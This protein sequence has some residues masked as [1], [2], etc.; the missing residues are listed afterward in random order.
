MIANAAMEVH[1]SLVC[2]LL[3]AAS[4]GVFLHAGIEYPCFV[5]FQKDSGLRPPEAPLPMLLA[6]VLFATLCI[7]LGVVRVGAGTL[8][9]MDGALRTASRSA[10]ARVLDAGRR[11]TSGNR[12]VS[13]PGTSGGNALWVAVMLAAYLIAYYV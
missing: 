11:S 13:R 2:Y 3:A 1:L 5:F 10:V 6:M 8:A 12:D 4:A 9:A 7:G